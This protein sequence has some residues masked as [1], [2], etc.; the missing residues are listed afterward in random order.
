VLS[1]GGFFGLSK[2]RKGL[3][4]LG[5]G[6]VVA[7]SVITVHAALQAPGPSLFSADPRYYFG[8]EGDYGRLQLKKGSLDLL[9]PAFPKDGI[10]NHP[11][12]SGS[13]LLGIGNLINLGSGV[14]LRV[15]GEYHKL[16]TRRLDFDGL[17]GRSPS[18]FFRRDVETH[19][20]FANLWM[21]IDLPDFHRTRLYVGGG[22]G[23]T[24]RGIRAAETVLFDGGPQFGFHAGGGVSHAL[25][26]N[27]DLT[28]GGRYL[29]LGKSNITNGIGDRLTLKH[30]G[31]EARIGLRYRLDSLRLR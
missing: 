15:E 14:S 31:F 25:N 16:G 3:I 27:V 5:A 29:H 20:A 23:L 13:V 17:A 18:D 10:L 21:D 4:A 28:V 8:V 6:V 22:I 1:V 12:G 30:S 24:T 7:V 9:T 11:V 2:T 26:R 19:S